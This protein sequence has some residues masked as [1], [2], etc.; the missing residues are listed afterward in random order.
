MPPA[1]GIDYFCKS[2]DFFD[3]LQ[4]P[5]AQRFAVLKYWIDFEHLLKHSTI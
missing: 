2:V 3:I 1:I 4:T 5:C